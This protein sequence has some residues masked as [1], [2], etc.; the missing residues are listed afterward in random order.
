MTLKGH[1]YYQDKC[2]HDKCYMDK[3]QSDSCSLVNRAGVHILQ[4]Y[5]DY[6]FPSLLCGWSLPSLGKHLPFTK[7]QWGSRETLSFPNDYL[8]PSLLCGYSLPSP[9]GSEK[10]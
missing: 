8:L 6:L 10:H 1:Y 2:Y 3:C 4:I 9:R 5:G 7:G